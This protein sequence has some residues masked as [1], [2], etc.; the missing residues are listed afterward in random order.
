MTSTRTNRTTPQAIGRRLRRA[1][2]F[3][4]VEL[5]TVMFIISLLI[6]LL[7]PSLNA[8]RNVAKKTATS[9]AL[10]SLTTALD[11]FR[12]DNERGF[13]Q[14]NGY[15]P[16][17][18]HPRMVASGGDDLFEPYL[19]E[20]PFLDQSTKPVITGAHW[21]PAMLMGFDQQGYIKRSTVPKKNDLRDE[22][23]NW[24]TPDPLDTGR[25]LD[26]VGFYADP[27]SLKTVLTGRLA[28]KSN[29][30]LFGGQTTFRDHI[31]NLPVIIDHFGQPILY[32]VANANGKTTNLVEEKRDQDNVY[33]GPTDKPGPPFYF[34]Q[35]NEAFTGNEMMRGWDFDGEHPIAFAGEEFNADELTDP[36]NDDARRSFARFIIDRTL[37]RSLEAKRDNDETI[38]TTTPLRP[39]NPDSYLLISAGVDGR[40]GTS[41]DV[42]N[43]PLAIEE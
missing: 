17:F 20:C 25:A 14:T 9:A 4:L 11:M 1:R 31:E 10:A 27:G 19:G 29:D 34:H 23:W 18:A 35:D 37:L 21:L 2:G 12:N 15:P 22:P 6:G 26:R 3:S 24:Y 30:D 32:Y 8:A 38:L 42:T 39:V 36:T 7:I 33:T 28:G 41:D 43:F 16:S 5:L 40:Y 13:S